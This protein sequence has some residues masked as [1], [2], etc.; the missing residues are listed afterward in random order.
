MLSLLNTASLKFYYKAMA[1]A[2]VWTYENDNQILKT[3]H[4]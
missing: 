1:Q 2:A 3:Q 4:A